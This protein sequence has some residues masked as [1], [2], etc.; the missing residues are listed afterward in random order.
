MSK[1]STDTQDMID[2]L[3]VKNEQDFKTTEDL[4]RTIWSEHYTPIIGP[5]QVS[6]MLDKFQSA[7][8]IKEQVQN[9]MEY[10]LVVKDG[11]AVGY[12]GFKWRD[13]ELFL[14][15]LYI[16]SSQ[17]GQK[18]GKKSLSFIY[19][20]AEEAGVK[21]ITLTVN[22]FNTIAISAYKKIGYKIVRPIIQDIGH[23]F[24]M[25]DYLMSKELQSEE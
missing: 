25:D 9:G 2:F 12:T 4:A 10:Y 19:S 16:L 24:I 18:L 13:D 14:S 15:K 7:S 17:R 1:K 3:P 8:A 6:Y 23:G 20:K 5:E 22:K 11:K 21:Q